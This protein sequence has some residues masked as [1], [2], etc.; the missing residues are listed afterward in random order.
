MGITLMQG[1]S[2]YMETALGAQKTITAA[3]NAD[4][5][6]F[7]SV[8]HGF[9]NGTPITLVTQGM[10]NLNGNDFR[11]I[12]VTA[13]TFQLEEVDGNG[14]STLDY[15]S[16]QSGYAREITY[17]VSI[18]DISGWNSSGGGFDML[19]AS[20][21][22]KRRKR[23]IP[24]AQNA[25]SVDFELIW[26]PT[27]LD[28]PVLKRESGKEKSFKVLYDN[29]IIEMYRGYIAFGGDG[30]GNAFDIKKAS[31]VISLL[32]DFTYYPS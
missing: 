11:V 25:S 16:F 15:S 29:G 13:D 20:V 17:G 8:A 18:N 5:G 22:T 30:N 9:S 23:Q 32:G 3:T 31:G 1:V 10:D 2:V 19:D 4:P 14:I 28:Q 27:S 12:N 6:V 21:I 7:T 24:G 26:D